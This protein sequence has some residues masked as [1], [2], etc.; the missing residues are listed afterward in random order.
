MAGKISIQ[1]DAN[2]Q[3]VTR[4]VTRLERFMDASSKRLNAMFQRSGGAGKG[5]DLLTKQMQALTKATD[6]QV[7]KVN[8][9]AQ[10]LQNVNK[11]MTG[12]QGPT[13][14]ALTAQQKALQRQFGMANTRLGVLQ[15]MGSAATQQ[16]QARGGGAGGAGGP[17][18]AVGN[19]LGRMGGLG[20]SVADGVLKMLPGI[21]ALLTVT[22]IASIVHKAYEQSAQK[23]KTLSDLMPRL[24]GAGGVARGVGFDRRL[25]H[26]G[27]PLGFTT[28]EGLAIAENMSS[29]GF[30][31]LN[32]L[33]R[34]TK[35]AM[36]MGRMFGIDAGQQASMLAEGGRMGAFKPGDAKKFAVM[37]ATEI[38]KTGLGPRAQEMQEAT[39]MLLNNQLRTQATAN[40]GPVMALQT[41]FN[42]TGLPAFTG[43]R[44]AGM[45]NQLNDSITNPK[46][47]AAEALN[48]QVFLKMGAKGIFDMEEMKEQGLSNK[49]YLPTLIKT[50]MQG[51]N[52]EKEARFVLKAQTGFSMT[53]W[54]E[55]GAKIPGGLA[56]ITPDR[57]G[58]VE[59][60]LK[61][62]VDISGGAAKTMNTKGNQLRMGEA[63]MDAV[64]QRIGDVVVDKV[65]PL[66]RWLS[67][68]ALPVF[69]M[70]DA[71]GKTTAEK[72]TALAD[73]F[74]GEPADKLMGGTLSN[75]DIA[76]AHALKG[77]QEGVFGEG[78]RYS[79]L[80]KLYP[81]AQPG[82]LGLRGLA[83]Q[84]GLAKVS[85]FRANSKTRGT[86][87]PSLHSLG[88]PANP[89]AFDFGG[90]P[91]K[92]GAFFDA[93]RQ[94]FGDANIKELIYSPKGMVKDGRYY[95]P[96]TFG[97]KTMDDH[98]DHVHGAVKGMGDNTLTIH[99]QHDGIVGPHAQAQIDHAVGKAID[100][101][102][103]EK[104]RTM[105]NK[106]NAR[107]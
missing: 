40:P 50:V 31:S 32:G 26:T 102:Q 42:K 77:M 97:K 6:A 12:S 61:H 103:T 84:Y 10:A 73:Y 95:A 49:N 74:I 99:V 35:T 69:N 17:G 15:Q 11:Q 3:G 96:G 63:T 24:L 8:T 5:V 80:N 75:P 54:K 71:S 90:A 22:G 89:G 66:S 7:Q 91:D 98:W 52:N 29:G 85:G 19:V 78:L 94:Q 62:G 1:L 72:T 18:G 67:D 107:Q 51:T 38:S 56:G 104:A 70:I 93:V 16:A 79:I 58:Q 30:S 28:N 82:A 46:S 45:I 100:K 106:R 59:N 86:G 43:S 81:D 23:E 2:A 87:R 13:L 36:Q 55:L 14:A 57:M 44:G 76:K 21:G 47:D 37:L 105:P 34:D 25:Q 101:K 92:M 68:K 41:L 27:M 88:T 48:Q 53:Q 9:L 39:L 33:Q 65:A 60:Y 20:G 4:E 83:A 64:M